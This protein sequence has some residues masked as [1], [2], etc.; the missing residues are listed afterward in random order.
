MRQAG[1]EGGKL[2]I[3]RTEDDNLLDQRI[4][5]LPAPEAEQL[6]DKGQKKQVR[7]ARAHGDELEIHA[8]EQPTEGEQEDHRQDRR[9]VQ[10]GQEEMGVQ[11]ISCLRELEI[12][13][14]VEMDRILGALSEEVSKHYHDIVNNQK[15]LKKACRREY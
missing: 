5:E 7:D 4:A 13:E 1:S 15:L 3:S 8:R 14:R 2:L 12:A 10:G 6:A 11:E 9:G